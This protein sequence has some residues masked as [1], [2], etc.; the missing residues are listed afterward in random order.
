MI[1]WG[2]DPQAAA[3]LG[4]F[5]SRNGPLEIE[6]GTAQDWLEA[7]LAARGHDIARPVMTSGLN[8]IRVARHG[9]LGGSDPRREGIA[10]GD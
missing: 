10:I 4:A 8:I 2:M 5:G 9:L 7:G 3:A 1:D 6:E